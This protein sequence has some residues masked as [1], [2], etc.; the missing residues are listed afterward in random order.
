[1]C[2]TCNACD[3][4]QLF[5]QCSE[6]IHTGGPYHI[7][8]A[9]LIPFKEG[10]S[11]ERLYWKVDWEKKHGIEK[12]DSACATDYNGFQ[13]KYTPIK[14]AASNFYLKPIIGPQGGSKY[15]RIATDPEDC[16]GFSDS[17][18][19]S[20]TFNTVKES[21]VDPPQ[22]SQAEKGVKEPMREPQRYVNVVDQQLVVELDVKQHKKD[23]SAFKLKNTQDGK[24]HPLSKSQWLP[25]A[26]MGSQPYILCRKGMPLHS[27]VKKKVKSVYI[28]IVKECVT[29]GR[30]MESYD[31][32]SYFFLEKGHAT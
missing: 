14:E 28:N 31:R 1:M 24:T 25:E 7:A 26:I 32:Y 27:K 16:R 4:Q 22:V 19:E 21:P 12:K 18:A 6:L 11:R 23:H 20:A 15:F 13:I 30:H 17:E 2:G 5:I 8:T 9:E 29:I 10:S 3:L